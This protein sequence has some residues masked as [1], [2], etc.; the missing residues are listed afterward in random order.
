[1]DTAIVAEEEEEKT[2]AKIHVPI[3]Q[4]VE[5]KAWKQDLAERKS[6][7]GSTTDSLKITIG[8]G[9]SE[10][11]MWGFKERETPSSRRKNVSD[12]SVGT[13]TLRRQIRGYLSSDSVSPMHSKFGHADVPAEVRKSPHT[14]NP[15]SA[16]S[17]SKNVAKVVAAATVAVPA[18]PVAAQPDSF[19]S[20]MEAFKGPMSSMYGAA[21]KPT[22]FIPQV[23]TGAEA[24]AYY[25]SAAY[26]PGATAAA[27]PMTAPPGMYPTQPYMPVYI[28]VLFQPPTMPMPQIPTYP[29]VIPNAAATATGATG[30]AAGGEILTGRIKFFDSTQNYGFF[31]LDC[32]GSDLFVHYD[33]FLKS[34]IT[35]EYIQMA[36]AMNTRFAFRRVS[37]Y[38]KYNLSSKAVDIQLIQGVYSS[39]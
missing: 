19:A 39:E 33:D 1:M 7:G 24:A 6:R 4:N 16:L 27:A 35:K 2:K 3:Y 5:Y 29:G 14:S 34:G 28:P 23:A 12:T 31:I 9:G 22:A 15:P 11:S 8:P 37:Y 38:G 21:T 17:S 30:G 10:E 32:N 18:T 13:P 25:A 36:K 26:Y 20:Y